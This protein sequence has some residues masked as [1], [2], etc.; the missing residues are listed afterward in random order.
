MFV[1]RVISSLYLLLRGVP[2]LRRGEV[3][4]IAK[5]APFPIV[6]GTSFPPL[7]GGD[8]FRLITDSDY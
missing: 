5:P 8:I 3:C 7:Q 1:Q 6:I 2:R 4:C